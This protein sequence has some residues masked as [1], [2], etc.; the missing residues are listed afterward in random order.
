MATDLPRCSFEVLGAGRPLVLIHG[1]TNHGLGWAPQLAGL[2][3]N[4]FRVLLPDLPGHGRSTALTQPVSVVDLARSVVA[5]LDH[6]AIDRTDV[7]GLSLG[8]MVAQEMALIAPERVD[9]LVLACTT[10]RASDAATISAVDRWIAVLEGP[11]GPRRRLND[12]W[13]FLTNEAYRQTPAARAVYSGWHDTLCTV[14]G[15]GLAHVARALSAFDALARLG[16]IKAP[17][18]VIAGERDGL[19]PP[20]RAQELAFAIPAAQLA[21]I[22]GAGHLANLDSTDQFNSTLLSFLTH[23]R[24][25]L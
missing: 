12:S 16:D 3:G 25:R 14:S 9:R 8:G 5:L 6:L 2:T 13:S 22:E 19:F 11:D 1:F 15:I 23:N 21:L 10:A 17:T 4:G 24:S 18:L 20:T 7:C